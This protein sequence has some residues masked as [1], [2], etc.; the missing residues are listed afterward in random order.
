M[1][2]IFFD[3]ENGIEVVDNFIDSKDIE[4]LYVIGGIYFIFNFVERS[5]LNVIRIVGSSR[6]EINVKIIEEFYKD[7]DIKNIYV[8][9]DG[10]RSK[11]DLI[12]F[13]VVGVLVFKNGFL[14]FLV[15][16]KLDSF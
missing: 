9:K 13:L 14:I 1:L 7:I 2:I 8:I 10:I 11:Y 5:L 4:K 15:G 12:D 6:S 16:N 3:L